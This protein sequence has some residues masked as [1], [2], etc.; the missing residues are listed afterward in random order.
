MC[1]L[2]H[3]EIPELVRIIPGSLFCSRCPLHLEF[4]PYLPSPRLRIKQPSLIPHTCQQGV[5]II[6]LGQCLLQSM[7]LMP[8]S[9]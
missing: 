7:S 5:P 4:H 3:P 1:S 9:W 8:G 2:D 6:A